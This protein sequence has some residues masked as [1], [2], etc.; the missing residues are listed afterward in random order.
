MTTLED[1]RR[2]ATHASL[3]RFEAR[4]RRDNRDESIRQC[5]AE[6]NA[7]LAQLAQATGLSKQRIH[8]IVKDGE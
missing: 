6:G 2:H 7:T 3:I 5:Y 8:M 1:V 4:S